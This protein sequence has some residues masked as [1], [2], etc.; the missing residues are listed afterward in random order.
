MGGFGLAVVQAG[1]H[2]LSQGVL[3]MVQGQSFASAALSG[4]AGS[5]AS[6]GWS[7]VIGASGG[8]MIA[9]GALAGGIGAELSGGNFW[10][11]VVI[12]GIVA[13]LNHAMHKLDPPKGYKGKKWVDKTGSYDNNNDGSWKATSPN[14]EKYT[15]IE[16]VVITAKARTN[17][18]NNF[19]TGVGLNTSI[20][21]GLLNYA[22]KSGELGKGAEKYL[23]FTKGIGFASGIYSMGENGY[24]FIQ[25]PNFY[26]GAKLFMSGASMINPW[27]GLGIGI[28]DASGGT[29]WVLQNFMG[30]HK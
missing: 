30:L 21:E 17:S 19:L 11:G 14:G 22:K 5:L 9:F 18:W 8:S 13:G 2:A 16:E 28:M 7:S 6:S 3:G 29:D 1:T 23:K 10:Q 24:N 12:G 4:F 15:F 27:I 25:K 20:K 26:N